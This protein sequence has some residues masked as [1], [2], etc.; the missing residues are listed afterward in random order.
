MNQ[1]TMNIFHKV[2]LAVTEILSLSVNLLNPASL[3]GHVCFYFI[4]NE[5]W[6]FNTS[7][8]HKQYEPP[9]ISSCVLTRLAAHDYLKTVLSLE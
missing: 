3:L 5:L 6:V 2:P 8:Q 9:V 1:S 7:S 4:L